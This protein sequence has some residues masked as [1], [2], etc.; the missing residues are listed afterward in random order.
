[1][2]DLVIDKPV[3]WWIGGALVYC[4]HRLLLSLDGV[5]VKDGLQDR[6]CPFKMLHGSVHQTPLLVAVE[7]GWSASKCRGCSEENDERARLLS[8]KSV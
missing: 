6:R 3:D 8:S 5:R 2:A 7:T 4:M 1:M